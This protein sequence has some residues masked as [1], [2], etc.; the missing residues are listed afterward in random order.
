MHHDEMQSLAVLVDP[1]QK[2]RVHRAAVR[3]GGDGRSAKGDWIREV[4]EIAVAASEAG[5]PLRRAP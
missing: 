2:A 4:L 5:D 3:D 1:E